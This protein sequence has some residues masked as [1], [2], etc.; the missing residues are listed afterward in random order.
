MP[1]D[2]TFAE[3]KRLL[4]AGRDR[5]AN[6]CVQRQGFDSLAAWLG[7][8]ARDA[9]TFDML[10]RELWRHHELAKLQEVITDG[11]MGEA[12]RRGWEVLLHAQKG[13]AEAVEAGLPPLVRLEASWDDFPAFF[14][15]ELASLK[16]LRSLDVALEAAVADDT[17]SMSFAALH[18]RRLCLRKQWD[19]SRHFE[20]WIVRAGDAAAEPVAAFLDVV[21]DLHEAAAVLPEV[22]AKHGDWMKRHTSTFGKAGYAYASSGLFAETAAW[23]KGCETRDDLKGWV[24]ANHVT[25]LWALQRYDEAGKVAAEVLRRDLRDATWDWN[26]SAAAFGHALAGRAAETQAAL[27]TIT[28]AS[29]KNAEFQWAA[30]LARSVLRALKLPCGEARRVLNEERQRLALVLRKHSLKLDHDAAS[31]RYRLA[32]TAIAAHGGFRV[33]PWQFRSAIERP[34]NPLRSWWVIGGV[35][36]VGLAVLR[37][38]LKPGTAGTLELLDQENK[39]GELPM[40]APRASSDEIDRLLQKSQ[41]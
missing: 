38:C 17:I 2:A 16:A 19:V 39:P 23:L 28:G 10:C 26:A 22:I 30:E 27:D 21:G 36:L 14:E 15:R 13:D 11:R 33:R 18:T 9:W 6:A 34:L 12:A 24:A 7:Q 3:V 40:D 25:A 4:D 32:L 37:G 20:K 1:E 35:L 8:Q 29:S 31:E 5:D 41:R